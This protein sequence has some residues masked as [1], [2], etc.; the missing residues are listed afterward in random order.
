MPKVF[1]LIVDKQTL[2]V[3]TTYK[4]GNKNIYIYYVIHL[5]SITPTF[6]LNHRPSVVI[7]STAEFK[8]SSLATSIAFATW[9]LGRLA[10]SWAPEDHHE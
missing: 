4:P 6:S 10:L 7:F 2:S 8:K 1:I 3:R 9:S 5:N